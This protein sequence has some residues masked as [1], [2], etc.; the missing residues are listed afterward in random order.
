M[1]AYGT[2]SPFAALQRFRQVCEDFCRTGDGAAMPL[3]DPLRTSLRVIL[4]PCMMAISTRA[5]W[6]LPQHNLI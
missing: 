4:R 1:P 2:H 3:R 5:V 6:N